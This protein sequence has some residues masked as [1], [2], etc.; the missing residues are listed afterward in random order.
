MAAVFSGVVVAVPTT[1][2]DAA[3]PAT[4]APTALCG[5]IP[6]WYWQVGTN[7]EGQGYPVTLHGTTVRLYSGGDT[8]GAYAKIWRGLRSDEILSIDRSRAEFV[9]EYRYTWPLTSQVEVKG[10]DYCERH[11]PTVGYGQTPSVDG[12][13]HAVRVC[14]R[15]AGALQCS[16]VWYSDQDS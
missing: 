12:F 8:G 9:G 4:P 13:H 14:L 7:W 1:P 15:R 11:G 2:A 5:S 16:N 6:D 10:W 3:A